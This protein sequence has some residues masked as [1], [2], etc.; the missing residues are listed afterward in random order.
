M[1]TSWSSPE[2][3]EPRVVWNL[4]S[5]PHGSASGAVTPRRLQPTETRPG[6]LAPRS[7]PGRD[8]SSGP[9]R[10]YSS[11]SGRDYSCCCCGAAG[12]RGCGGIT[13]HGVPA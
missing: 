11:G 10:D 13:R 7:G 1:N 8:Y 5:R 4:Q 2:R 6:P 9:G 3:T 12:L